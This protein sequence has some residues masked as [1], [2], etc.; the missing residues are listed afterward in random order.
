MCNN[1]KMINEYYATPAVPKSV[2]S[3]VPNEQTKMKNSCEKCVSTP[4]KVFYQN[5]SKTDCIQAKNFNTIP[6]GSKY[7]NTL[8]G[9]GLPVV[10]E[11]YELDYA[12]YM[13]TA[14]SDI[15]KDDKLK[16]YIGV[17]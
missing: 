12:R 16:L 9:C 14:K 8:N 10:K 7:S 17:L 11:N 5:N 15:W 3:I 4:N 2:W 1:N 13:N 6:S